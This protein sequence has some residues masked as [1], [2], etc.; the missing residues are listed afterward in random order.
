MKNRRT[1]DSCLNCKHCQILD[2][3][4]YNDYTCLHNAKPKPYKSEHI[5]AEE[6][7]SDFC[8]RMEHGTDIVSICDAWEKRK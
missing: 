3:F 1:V 5:T 4:D 6:Y 7:E 2:G 8:W